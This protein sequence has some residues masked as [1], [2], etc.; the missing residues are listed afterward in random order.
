MNAVDDPATVIERQVPGLVSK[1]SNDRNWALSGRLS[2]KLR[3][4]LSSVLPMTGVPSGNSQD[5]G[6]ESSV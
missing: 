5:F 3:T 2:L 6:F 4:G 1:A